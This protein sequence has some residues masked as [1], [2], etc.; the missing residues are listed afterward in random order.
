MN[1]WNDRWRPFE[2]KGGFFYTVF[3]CVKIPRTRLLENRKNENY[4]R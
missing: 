1:V 3:W 4:E 2:S